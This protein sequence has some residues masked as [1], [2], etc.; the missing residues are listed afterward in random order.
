MRRLG[1][2]VTGWLDP[3]TQ[4]ATA[5]YAFL[6]VLCSNIYHRGINQWTLAAL[7]LMAGLGTLSGLAAIMGDR[8]PPLDPPGEGD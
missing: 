1:G 4:R 2:L 6:G 7:V 3:K 5:F 8:E